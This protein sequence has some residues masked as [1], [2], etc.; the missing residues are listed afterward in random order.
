[1]LTPEYLQHIADDLEED[2]AELETKILI[3]LAERIKVANYGVTATI[4]WQKE[5][6]RL[7]G[8]SDEEIRKLLAEILNYSEE[9]VKNILEQ[10]VYQSVKTDDAI[11]QEAA[12]KGLLQD[13]NLETGS[14]KKHILQGIKDLNA[15]LSNICN[16]TAVTARNKLTQALNDAYLKIQ[17]GAFS[18]DFVMEQTIN[19]LAKDG[20]GTIEYR[21]GA[22]RQLDT[23]VRTAVRTAVAQASAKAQE[24]HMDDM[25][26]NLVETT[27]H[28]GARPTHAEWQGK[29]FW[30]N[31]AVEG[32]ENFYEATG[33]GTGAGLCGWN[34]R[35]SFYPFFE[36]LSTQSFEHFDEKENEER[37]NLEQ[38]QRYN[39]RKIREWKRRQAVNK[40]G[41]IDTTRETQKVREWQQK[42]TDF[43][44]KHPE[45]K[46]NH[47][48]EKVYTEKQS[49]NKLK[50]FYAMDD[51]NVRMRV[52]NREAWI[53]TKSYERAYIY[54]QNGNKLLGKIG[55][56]DEV[57]FTEKELKLMKDAVV[58]H[59][60]PKGV[61][62]SP[63][64]IYM[65]I[66]HNLQEIRA[67]G[68]R[69]T[70][71]LRRNENLHLMPSKEQ[72]LEEYSDVLKKYSK[73][74]MK[75]FGFKISEQHY[76]QIIQM[77]GM[78]EMAKK[79]GLLYWREK[80]GNI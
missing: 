33:Y 14:L 13:A 53:Y 41:G 36:G 79:Y 32:Y 12:N 27:S 35:H 28:M 78:N 38:E 40:A 24:S 5:R 45:L 19:N 1:M 55:T 47:S 56:L 50:E 3:E 22:H 26:V 9:K 8:M 43:L 51:K 68:S 63:D 25:G 2:F 73:L 52:E 20:L 60:H 6:L 64:D 34:C 10:S 11:L 21:S 70:Y 42:Q 44:K 62:L 69:G 77:N 72:F 61:T 66:E 29:V 17:S 67:T 48:R 46:R 37:Y 49:N 65:A 30:R 76:Q 7:L 4:K 59:N 16:T 58:T 18:K 39:E 74:Y 71:V 31:E 23:T 75:K 80:N 15:E 54:D 57:E